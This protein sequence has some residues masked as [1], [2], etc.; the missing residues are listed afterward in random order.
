MFTINNVKNEENVGR[1]NPVVPCPDSLA[2]V[3]SPLRPL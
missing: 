1:K 2:F 3:F